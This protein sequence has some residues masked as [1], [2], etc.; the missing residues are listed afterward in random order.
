MTS[1][2]IRASKF[3]DVTGADVISYQVLTNSKEYYNLKYKDVCIA[4]ILEGY[5]ASSLLLAEWLV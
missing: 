1:A 3:F 5:C 4:K 2:P